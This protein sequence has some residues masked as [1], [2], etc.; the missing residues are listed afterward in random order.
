MK[1]HKLP[2]TVLAD[3]KFDYFKKFNV[4]KS[5]LKLIL[6]FILKPHKFFLAG[7]KGYLPVQF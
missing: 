3:E 6:A 5:Y 7:L 4:E 1:K 2:F